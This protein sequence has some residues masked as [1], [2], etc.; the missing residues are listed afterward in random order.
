[1]P[2]GTIQVANGPISWLFSTLGL[3]LISAHRSRKEDFRRYTGQQKE[4]EEEKA[5]TIRWHQSINSILLWRRQKSQSSMALFFYY[6]LG[7]RGTFSLL[8]FF[9]HFMKHSIVKEL[10]KYCNAHWHRKS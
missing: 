8:F 6:S 1:M 3:V 7:P 9:S 4:N 10:G 2:C 5:K